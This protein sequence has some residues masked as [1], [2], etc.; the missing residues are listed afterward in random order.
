MVAFTAHILNALDISENDRK[1][2]TADTRCEFV[3]VE[4][5]INPFGNLPKQR[6]ACLMAAGIVDNLEPI[7]IDE[8]E[9]SFVSRRTA[10]FDRLAHM[11][12][13]KRAVG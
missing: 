6:I 9:G 1:F 13:Q 3:G 12:G 11:F 2:V 4:R 10:F 5:A 7:E 8:Q